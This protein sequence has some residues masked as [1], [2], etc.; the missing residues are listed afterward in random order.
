MVA[1]ITR[2][3]PSRLRPRAIQPPDRK[4]QSARKCHPRDVWQQKQGRILIERVER[5]DRRGDG[6]PEKNHI[7]ESQI[8][9]A[10]A[11]EKCRPGR[12]DQQAAAIDGE[13]HHCPGKAC[14][15]PYKPAGYR[16]CQV[17]DAPC[18]S[19]SPLGRPPSWL[20]QTLVPLP[21]PEHS[22]RSRRKKTDSDKA[23]H[24]DNGRVI[25]R[26]HVSTVEFPIDR[27]VPTNM[28]ARWRKLLMRF[29]NIFT[30]CPHT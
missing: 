20:P 30:R 19:K 1:T 15:A 23:R 6:Q 5:C 25:H 28:A 10:K 8:G 7:H 2:Q 9:A 12:V 11:E 26:R 21:G 27:S 13:R 29:C 17:Q 22:S 3:R 4:I 14:L 18:G 24:N 16:N